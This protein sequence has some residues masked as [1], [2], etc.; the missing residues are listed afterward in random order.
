MTRPSPSITQIALAGDLLSTPLEQ[1]TGLSVIAHCG[2]PDCPAPRPIPV[3]EV[4]AQRPRA[5]VCDVASKFHCTACSRAARAVSL[6]EECRNG[7]WIL[8][9]V[10]WPQQPWPQQ[11]WSE[12]TGR[13][14]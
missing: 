2:D 10:L 13:M 7:S 14:Q 9:P 3:A 6:R 4:L 8:Q 11:L 12:Q 1:L 5:R